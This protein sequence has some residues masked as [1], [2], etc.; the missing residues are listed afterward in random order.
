MLSALGTFAMGY[1][2]YQSCNPTGSASSSAISSPTLSAA[3][4]SLSSAGSLEDQIVARAQKQGQTSVSDVQRAFKTEY[5]ETRDLLDNLARAGR[6]MSHGHGKTTYYTVGSVLSSSSFAVAPR[7]PEKALGDL[8]ASA[9][10]AWE[11]LVLSHPEW[12]EGAR[13]GVPRPGHPEGQIVFHVIEVLKNVDTW[14]RDN[15]VA[16]ADREKLRLIAMIH[17]TFKH[18]VNRSVPK[19]G[20]NHHAMIARRFAERI[21]IKDVEILEVIEHHDDAYNA[22][23]SGLRHGHDES[24]AVSRLRTLAATLT[25]KKVRLELYKAFYWCDSNTGSKDQTPYTWFAARWPR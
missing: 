14:C 22:Y 11:R 12:I 24:K 25:A 21:G 2:I 1:G 17:D 23:N 3:T 7:D 20:E 19:S 16:P 9:E 10:S 13:Q 4:S 15:K 18:K 8:L 5:R 6:L